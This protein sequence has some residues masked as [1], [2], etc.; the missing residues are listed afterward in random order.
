VA[1]L[2]ASCPEV[3]HQVQ[4][5]QIGVPGRATRNGGVRRGTSLADARAL[6]ASA[7][8]VLLVS[9]IGPEVP[10]TLIAAGFDVYAKVGPEP[11][12]WAVCRRDLG[13]FRNRNGVRLEPISRPP[14]RVDLLHLDVSDA[15][16]ECLGVAKA[17]GAR[18]FWFHS[19][20]TCPPERRPRL[21]AACGAIGTSATSRRIRRSRVHQRPTHRRRCEIAA[22][23]CKSQRFSTAAAETSELTGRA[24]PGVR[25]LRK[26]TVP[27]MCD[28]RP[29]RKRSL[30][31]RYTVT[32]MA[33]PPD[34]QGRLR[35]A[36][37]TS[38]YDVSQAVALLSPRVGDRV[39]APD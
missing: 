1:R 14:E 28:D 17:L 10:A 8:Q 25:S 21:L 29:F 33:A 30:L 34:R 3:Q 32:S 38:P 5:P 2:N 35:S 6:L 26:L 18:T 7:R 13:D 37:G 9:F 31:F 11:D 20:R 27:S 22:L 24:P 4:V 15:F 16:D 12:A 19:A 39:S 36:A 23:A